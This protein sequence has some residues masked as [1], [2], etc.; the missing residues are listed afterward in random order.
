M[1]DLYRGHFVNANARDNFLEL[2]CTLGA[3]VLG[4]DALARRVR[5]SAKLRIV[6][7]QGGKNI[8]GRSGDENFGLRNKEFIEPFPPI[9]DNGRAACRGF[10]Q[11]A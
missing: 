2:N 4:Q 3:G 8:L 5:D 11:T 9:A 7:L 6:G 1:P 10:K